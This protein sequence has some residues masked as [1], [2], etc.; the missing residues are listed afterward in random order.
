MTHRSSFLVPALSGVACGSLAKMAATGILVSLLS[1]LCI[2]PVSLWAHA[3]PDR[4]DPKVG[5][6][7]KSSPE[8]IRIWFDCDLEPTSSKLMVRNAE[9]EIVDKNDSRVDAADP[10]LLEVSVP[11]LPPGRYRVIWS[12][13]ARDGH[14]SKGDFPFKV[15]R[16]T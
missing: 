6:T 15:G 7:V 11:T 13:M 1:F 14:R 8:I 3:L 9:N 16:G 2:F 4:S 12:V 5:A 10:K